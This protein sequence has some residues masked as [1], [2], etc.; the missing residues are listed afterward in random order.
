[1]SQHD[2]PETVREVLDDTMTFAPAALAALRVF[3]KSHPW[4]G[5]IE[6][7]H[8]KIRTLHDA[9]CAAYGLNPPPRLIFGG[10]HGTCSGATLAELR[11]FEV[12][13]AGLLPRWKEL[14]AW[15]D[16]CRREAVSSR[17][18]AALELTE[19]RLVFLVR[20]ERRLEEHLDAARRRLADLDGRVGGPD[21]A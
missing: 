12:E 11:A 2:Y 5:S 10:D 18:A 9:L 4:T 13:V 21:S 20:V 15:L 8:Q 14:H 3:K 16:R 6:E 1:M 19:K 7:R 17:H